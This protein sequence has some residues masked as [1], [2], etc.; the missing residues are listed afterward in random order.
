M[1]KKIRP[2]CWH[3]NLVPW[4]L[5]V[6]A[7][8]LY[9]CIKSW[10]KIKCIK[11]DFKDILLELAADERSDKTFLLT[12]KLCPLGA[13]CPC[14]GA[15][16][17]YKIVNIYIY[18]YIYIYKIRLQKRFFF[19]LAVNERSYKMFL[20]TSKFRSQG[21][22]APAL[23]LYTCIKSLK[24]LYKIRPKRF[25]L[26]LVANDRS[27]KRF[28]L[29]SKFCPQGCLPLPWGY[30]HLL[31][32]EKMCRKSDVEEILFKLATNEHSD[33]AFLLTSKFWP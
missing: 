17:M 8:G 18:I 9:T 13:V 24:T 22:S 20:L 16:S 4:W 33:E 14:P 26:K 15:I 23:G 27:D 7:P 6:P 1:G 3:P 5:S 21:L 2:F 31:N 19:K 32:H 12:S 11:S 28:L 30:I 29:T 25:V 10:K